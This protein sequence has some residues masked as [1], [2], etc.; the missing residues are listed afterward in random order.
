MGQNFGASI[1]HV[2]GTTIRATFLVLLYAAEKKFE[3]PNFV[4]AHDMYK[5]HVGLRETHLERQ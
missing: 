1:V 4:A 3:K 2:P 5:L